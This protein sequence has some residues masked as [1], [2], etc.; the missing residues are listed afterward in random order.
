MPWS[1]AAP[2]AGRDWP[3]AAD[4]ASLRRRW[5]AFTA[6]GPAERE[7]LLVPSRARG[8]H[9][10]VA[11]LP[12]GPAGTARLAREN[13]P[14]PDPVLVAHGPF[15]ERFLLPDHRLL[16]AARPELWRVADARQW[17]LVE[18]GRSAEGEF[19]ALTVSGR[20]PFG[21]DR[22]TRVRPL[23]RRPGG[24][25]PNL[26]PGLLAFLSERYG[27]EVTA[28][29]FAAWALAAARP[30]PGGLAVPLPDGAPVWERG[31]ALGRALRAA[32]TRGAGGDR[33]RLPGGR[34]P[35]VR[36]TLPLTG[37]G[38]VPALAFDPQE[39][40]LLVGATGLVSPVSRAAWEFRLRG[41]RVIERWFAERLPADTGQGS[42][43][44]AGGLAA[45]GPADWP[46]SWTSQLLELITVL[47]LVAEAREG[48]AAL[49]A[50]PG[51]TLDAQRLRAAG[52]LPAPAAARRPASVLDHLEEGPEGQF[53]LL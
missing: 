52:V 15:D 10:A 34:R 14:C 27:A 48:C 37:R 36:R 24:V 12:G 28:R 42:P 8:L 22:P 19:P 39:E 30:G 43:E 47:T 23:Y 3:L 38:P 13:G 7:R 16:D 2:R 33:P 9:T 18:R 20:L 32:L 11:Q 51:P 40:A 35:Y 44:T 41:E 29:D 21:E 1:V 49:A 46:Q 17:F 45:L 53:A 26:A 5:S 31:V 50:A 25:E 6:A 4:E